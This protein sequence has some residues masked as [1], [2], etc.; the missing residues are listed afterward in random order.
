MCNAPSRCDTALWI[1]GMHMLTLCYQGKHKAMFACETDF[2]T[3]YMLCT[4][5]VQTVLTQQAMQISCAR[6]TE[7]LQYWLDLV[8]T[9]LVH[10]GVQN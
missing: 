4:C 7:E 8:S 5:C 1:L 9:L 3:V 10:V 6:R 2:H